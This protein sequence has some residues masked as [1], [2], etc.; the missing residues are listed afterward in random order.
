LFLPQ[1]FVEPFAVKV[2]SGVIL[3]RR[4]CRFHR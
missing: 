3:A 4:S 1:L 2:T